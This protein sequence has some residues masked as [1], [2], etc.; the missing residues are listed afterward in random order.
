[1]LIEYQNRKKYRNIEKNVW[2]LFGIYIKKNFSFIYL[3]IAC[4]FPVSLCTFF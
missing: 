1:M 2:Q 3:H 4:I